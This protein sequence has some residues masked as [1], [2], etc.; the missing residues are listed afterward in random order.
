MNGGVTLPP[1]WAGRVVMAELFVVAEPLEDGVLNATAAD[2]PAVDAG[3][4][5]AELELVGIVRP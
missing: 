5:P 4:S 1:G 2:S 3:L